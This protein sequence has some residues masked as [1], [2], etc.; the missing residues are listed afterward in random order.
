MRIPKV[1]N[2][3]AALAAAMPELGPTERRVAVALYRGLAEGRPVAPDAL[4]A[5]VGLTE[6]EVTALLGSW[7]GVFTDDA[8][9][10]IGFWG[11][12]LAETRHRLDLDGLTLYAWCAW[13]ALFL[14]EI[15]GRPAR[16]FSPCPV[17]GE[18][19]SLRVGVSGVS[20]LSPSGAV[21]S[22]LWPEQSFDEHILTSFC[23]YI[24]F[25]ASEQAGREWVGKHPG[26][27]LL[28]VED[29]FRLGQ[30]VNRAKFGDALP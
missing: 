22:L 23:H 27:F 17:T 3:A 24:F 26:T 6:D 4:A 13:D 8:G 14:P 29:G 15:L 5:G 19:V 2:L 9:G 12:A 25:F 7:P 10:V 18:T 28:P 11:L 20:E 30:L 1:E 21:L 16:V